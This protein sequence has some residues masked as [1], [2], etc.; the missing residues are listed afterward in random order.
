[1][2]L[3]LW[4]SIVQ[5]LSTLEIAHQNYLNLTSSPCATGHSMSSPRSKKHFVVCLE[6]AANK[7]F[8]FDA[9]KYVTYI[10]IIQSKGFQ[11][12]GKSDEISLNHGFYI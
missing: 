9:K 5:Q 6:L 7:I 2:P 12:K 10:L 1:M 11:L 4:V 8:Q 3:K